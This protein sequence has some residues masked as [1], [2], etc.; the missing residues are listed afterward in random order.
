V[1]HHRRLGWLS[2]WQAAWINLRA[3]FVYGADFFLVKPGVLLLVVGLVLT[4]PLTFGQVW[5]G[6]IAFSLHWS[7]AGVALAVLGLQSVY[8]GTLA[9]MFYES[10]GAI[11]RRWLDRLRYN[12]AVTLSAIVFLVGL[13]LTSTLVWEYVGHDLSLPSDVLKSVS[14]RAVTGVLLMIMGFMTF[15][16]TLVVHAYDLVARQENRST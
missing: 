3:M 16:F 1:S 4:L 9:R 5:I 12:R 11:R 14:Y 10:D 13:V 2:P 15:T 8:L 6:P 7:I